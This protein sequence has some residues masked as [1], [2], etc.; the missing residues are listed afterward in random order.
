MCW[1]LEEGRGTRKGRVED[2]LGFEGWHPVLVSS[3]Q[4]RGPGVIF[5]NP[6]GGPEPRVL[7]FHTDRGSGFPS[8]TRLT[9]LT[10]VAGG[11]W[12]GA[13]TGDGVSS[14]RAPDAIPRRL[15]LFL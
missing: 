11:G 6:H 14:W 1:N 5:F 7:L 2:R 9:W 10:R 8:V 3:V 12:G 15:A 13:V 4:F